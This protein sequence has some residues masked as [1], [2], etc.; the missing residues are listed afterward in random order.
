[1]RMRNRLPLALALAAAASAPALAGDGPWLSGAWGN[2]AGCAF[3]AG[4]TREDYA[5]LCEFLQVLQGNGAVVVTALCG[6][7]GDAALTAET[8]IVRMPPPGGDDARVVTSAAGDEWASV[9]PCK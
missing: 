3:H 9:E 4:G 5:T 8:L 6:H 1:M 7:E 2:A